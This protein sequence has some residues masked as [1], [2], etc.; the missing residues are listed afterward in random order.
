MEGGQ[1]GST[2]PVGNQGEIDKL[3]GAEILLWGCQS[4]NRILWVAVPF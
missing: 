3:V 1:I 2:I 4:E